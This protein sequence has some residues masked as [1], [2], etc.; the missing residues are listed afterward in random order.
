MPIIGENKSAAMKKRTILPKI[1][2]T[3]DSIDLLNTLNK[4][5]A[6]INLDFLKAFDRVD[7]ANSLKSF[8]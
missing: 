4:L 7:W 3:H 8:K 2:I 1:F 6:I 5:L